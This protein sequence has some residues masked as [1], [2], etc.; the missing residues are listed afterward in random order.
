MMHGQK[1]IK[2]RQTV[3]VCHNSE[4]VGAVIVAVEMQYVLQILSV[5]L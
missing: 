5:R 1:N 2:L 3:Y 4:E